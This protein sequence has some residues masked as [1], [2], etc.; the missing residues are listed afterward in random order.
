M[1]R[2]DRTYSSGDI[3]RFWC[4]NLDNKEKNEVIRFFWIIVPGLLVR[5]DLVRI[6]LEKVA[7]VAPQRVVRVIA[8]VVSILLK[9]LSGVGVRTW[10]NILF[11]DK[12][13]REAI[14]QCIKKHG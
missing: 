10:V 5:L 1:A 3:I 6:I 11:Q 2:I 4:H 8:R 7:G 14:V 12:S 9:I 13:T